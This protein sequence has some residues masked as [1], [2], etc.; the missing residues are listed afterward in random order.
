MGVWCSTADVGDINHGDIQ[1][2][3]INSEDTYTFLTQFLS[4]MRDVF[5]PEAGAYWQ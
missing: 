1:A 3:K 4:E 5:P 2:L